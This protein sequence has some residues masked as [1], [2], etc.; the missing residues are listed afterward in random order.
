MTDVFVHGVL[1]KEFGSYFCFNVR[2]PKEVINAISVNKP[3]FYHRITELSKEG[4]HY[5]ILVDGKNIKD[6]NQLN[7]KK[8]PKTIDLVPIICGSGPIAATLVT[9]FKIAKTTAAIIAS[10]F[11]TAVS[12]GVQ[13]ALTN[14]IE[15]EG[16]ESTVSASD[17]SFAFS[18]KAN[19]MQQGNPVPVGYGRL[20]VGS[21][22][23]QI[24]IKNYPQN[25]DSESALVSNLEDNDIA[26]VFKS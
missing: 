26:T 10:V 14:P 21:S 3:N 23:V 17:Q 11:W 8:T 20:R 13:Y 18:S 25:F 19:R 7:I 6:S 4:L 16:V 12:I 2:K 9:V 15:Q 22:V 5:S 1:A 24:T